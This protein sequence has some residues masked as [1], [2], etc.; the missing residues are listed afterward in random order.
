MSKKLFTEKEI[1]QLSK[2]PYVKTVSSKGITYTDEFKQY[3]VSEFSKG[4]FSRQIF[5]EAGF[6]VE[7]IGMNRIKSAS[8]RWRNTYKTEGSLGLKDTR[9]GNSGRPR[10]KELSLEEKY[11]RLEA[12]MN[13]VKAENELPKKDSYVRRGAEEV[14]LPAS[15]KYILICEVIE[16]YNL[17][18]MVKFLC[19]ATG[20]SRSGYYNYFSAKSEEQRKRQE[21]KDEEAKEIILKAFHF[22]GRKKG[23][24]QIKMTLAGQFQCVYNLKK[25]RRVM[26]KFNIFCPIRKA[27]PYRRMMK[28]TKEHRVVSNV[29]NRQFKQDKPGK[30]L[31]T[32][33]TYLNYYGGQRAYLSVIKDGSTGEV[34]A[35]YMSNRITMELATNTLL[36]LKKNRKFKKAEDALIHSD[37][38]THYTHPDF[39]KLVRKLGLNQSMSRRGNCWDNA[40]IESFFGHLKDEVDIK[41]CKTFEELKQDIDKYIRHYNHTRYQWN[42][43]KMTPVQYRNHLLKVA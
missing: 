15:Q 13:L 42:L 29:L 41:A 18:N 37:Q 28:A 30:V 33:I 39:Q 24:R 2:N 22:K 9:K 11:A 36:K 16:K 12:Q 21:K 5:E 20:V 6:E 40:P 7:I 25:I 26:K 43:K 1:T 14:R 34:L 3:F 23:A 31:L 4:K 35:H 8:E 38:G 19:E 27:N 32:D 10:V 17:K